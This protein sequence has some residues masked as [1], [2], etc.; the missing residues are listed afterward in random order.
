MFVMPLQSDRAT[1]V[2]KPLHFLIDDEMHVLKPHFHIMVHVCEGPRTL[3]KS[4]PPLPP[5]HLK[6][7]L[8]FEV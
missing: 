7:S 6:N 8:W 4:T 1:H 2:I 5:R 3:A